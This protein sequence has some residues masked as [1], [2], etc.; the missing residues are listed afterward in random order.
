MLKIGLISNP[1]SRRNRR[2]LD[3]IHRLVAGA[4]E[5]VHVPTDVLP[6]LEDVLLELARQEVGVIVVNGGDG[7]VQRLIT[8]LLERRPFEVMPP[9]AILRRGMANTTAR[10]VGLLGKPAEALARLLAATRNGTI[11]RHLEPHPVL[12]IAN[13]DGGPPQRGMFLGAGAVYDGIELCCREVYARG[14]KGNLGIGFT[15][16]GLLLSSALGMRRPGILRGHDI[17][18]ALD[19]GPEVQATRL[20]VMATTLDHQILQTRPFWNHA[21]APIRYTSI[22]YPPPHL[23]RSAPKVLYGWRRETLSPSG[24]DSHGAE[25]L[26]IRLD[27]PFTL[28]GET[29]HPAKDQPLAITAAERVSFV[30]L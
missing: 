14:L 30:R 29:F 27:A 18:V 26:T 15:L 5:M 21:D 1:K 25:C 6:D 23:M 16:G 4:P 20:L 24:Y 9:L 19:R 2:G 17:S 10:N 3:E 11:T 8:A 28:D 7:T 22:T 12:R 13:V